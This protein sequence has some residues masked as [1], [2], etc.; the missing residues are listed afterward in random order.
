MSIE[1]SVSLSSIVDKL[2]LNKVYLPENY[3][4]IQITTVEINRPGL[5]LT[6]YL[7][8]FDGNRIIVF[9][10]TE[11]AYLAQFDEE[12]QFE[13]IDKLLSMQPPAIIIARPTIVSKI[14]S[15]IGFTF[16]S[17]KIDFCM[18]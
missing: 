12:K 6:G 18:I 10:N 3:E 13:V 2:K 16:F 9:G 14:E 4:D 17:C 5:E 7:D 1:F 15:H 11:F 8:F